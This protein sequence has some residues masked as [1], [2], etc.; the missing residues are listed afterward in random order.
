MGPILVVLLR[1]LT[2]DEQDHVTVLQTGL[3]WG[4]TCKKC[5]IFENAKLR[6]KEESSTE[7]EATDILLAC[8]SAQPP[9]PSLL[10]RGNA[11]AF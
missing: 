8:A 3:T 7:S 2:P 9:V 11:L 1:M 4:D 5:C 6:R 10:K